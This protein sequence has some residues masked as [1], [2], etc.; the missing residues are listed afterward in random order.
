MLSEAEVRQKINGMS[1][2]A[3]KTRLGDLV[4]GETVSG[5]LSVSGFSDGETRQ[6]EIDHSGDAEF[7][8]PLSIPVFDAAAGFEVQ[9]I[10]SGTT[11]K[12]FRVA[13]TH[14]ADE[15]VYAADTPDESG[16]ASE[17]ISWERTGIAIQP[18]E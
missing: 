5:T 12:K 10:L 15:Y 8:G 13:V 7:V 9:L 2:A 4:L 3:A 16:D 6:Y 11:G 14:N 18:Y 1:P 17:D